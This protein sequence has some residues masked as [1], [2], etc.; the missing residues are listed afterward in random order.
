M[1]RETFIRSWGNLFPHIQ[2][3]PVRSNSPATE[4]YFEEIS[5]ADCSQLSGGICVERQQRYGRL[6]CIRRV[7]GRRTIERQGGN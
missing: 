3:Q 4:I 2:Q 6:R 7:R 5:D 1:S